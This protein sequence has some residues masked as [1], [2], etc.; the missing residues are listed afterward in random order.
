M[1]KL[2]AFVLTLVIV[3]GFAATTQARPLDGPVG[4]NRSVIS[5]ETE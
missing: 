5:I 3:M 2:V 4:S 1:K